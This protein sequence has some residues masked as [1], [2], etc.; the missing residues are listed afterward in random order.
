MSKFVT[1]HGFGGS[2]SS[3]EL[4]F[5]VVGG[6]IQP[7]NPEE[8]TIWI[9]TDVKI[10]SYI[11]SV[12]EPESLIDGMVWISTY[13]S[14]PADFNALKDNNSI[15]V[16]PVG[17][18][19]YV[20]REWVHVDAMTYQNGQWVEWFYY[21]Y[22]SGDECSDQTS[23]WSRINGTLT[24]NSDNFVL[25]NVGASTS[26][27]AAVYTNA[28]MDLTGYETLHAVARGYYTSGAGYSTFM[29]VSKTK[30]TNKN[31]VT[32]II[33]IQENLG[34]YVLNVSSLSGTYYIGFMVAG[35][36]STKDIEV[37]KVWRR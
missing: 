4:N 10:T 12:T 25:S 16:Y 26:S 5:E 13:S 35:S 6:T 9:N 14:S 33:D 24:K 29:V 32:A 3:S 27:Y 31:N 21:L 8:N 7:N 28:M 18:K 19:Q 30:V 37:Q 11:F 15:K 23:G 2:G 36:S 20:N 34:E 1:L 22:N 17:A